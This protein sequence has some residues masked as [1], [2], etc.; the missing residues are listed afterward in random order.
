V[1]LFGGWLALQV[2]PA[3]AR[4][5][6]SLRGTLPHLIQEAQAAEQLDPAL[7]LYDLQIAYLMGLQTLDSA[8]NDAAMQ[9]AIAAYTSALAVEPTWDTGWLNLG[10]LQL[11]SGDSQAALAAFTEAQR[12]NPLTFAPLNRAS[13]AETYDLLPR[14]PIIS[15]YTQA[16]AN[17]IS[18]NRLPLTPFWTATPLR[19][20]ALEA[21]LQ[22]APPEVQYRVYAVHDP[23]CAARLVATAPVTAAEWWVAGEHALNVLNDSQAAVDS[24]SRAIDRDYQRG[25]YYAARARALLARDADG[26]RDAAAHDLDFA[27]L[28]GVQYENINLIRAALEA[29]PA[30]AE[31]L[32]QNAYPVPFPG[33]EFAAVLYGGRASIFDLFPALRPPS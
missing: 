17:E 2:N 11:E 1:V 15:A 13:T 22:T 25:D 6:N 16:I 3:Y 7:H 12:I 23:A 24:F 14:S 4:Y 19:L 28:L 5:L 21:Y 26:D 33:Q 30:A 10:A 18:A 31:L 29:D 9:A 32:R 27:Y 20:A 8:S